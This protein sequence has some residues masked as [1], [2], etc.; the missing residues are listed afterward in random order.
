MNIESKQLRVLYI[1]EHIDVLLNTNSLNE[2]VLYSIINYWRLELLKLE[3]EIRSYLEIKAIN[4]RKFK[5]KN[6]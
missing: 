6:I 5:L 2:P 4:N 3:T 1:R